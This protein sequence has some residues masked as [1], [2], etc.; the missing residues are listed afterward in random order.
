M[1]PIVDNLQPELR[2][3]LETCLRASADVMSVLQAARASGVPDW[4]LLSGAVY[5]TVWNAVTG[6]PAGYGV[7]DYDIAYFDPDLA[8]TAETRWAGRVRAHLPEVLRPSVEIA[9]QARVHLWFERKFGRA[10]P[11]LSST[12]EALTRALATAHAVGVRLE[13]GGALTIAAPYGLGDVVDL[14]LRCN[15]A[16]EPIAAF[17]AK[18]LE[19]RARWPEVRIL[20]L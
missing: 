15:P 5:Q 17:R 20:H 16:M 9:N 11:P 2:A 13:H 3:R 4:R 14:V 18:A 8:E 1:M 10:Y 7:R 6:R 12:D 19:A